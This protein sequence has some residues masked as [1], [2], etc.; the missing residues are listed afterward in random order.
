MLQKTL[1]SLL[2]FVAAI[3]LSQSAQ[4]KL[5]LTSNVTRA[6]VGQPFT[7]RCE[8]ENAKPETKDYKIEF[9]YSVNG[10][11]A[12][13]DFYS[14]QWLYKII[15]TK[16]K[17]NFFPPI[18]LDSF[19]K[20]DTAFSFQANFNDKNQRYISRL[21]PLLHKAHSGVY[22]VVVVA[23]TNFTTSFYCVKPLGII[24]HPSNYLTLAVINSHIPEP[25]T[26]AKPPQ[27]EVQ[28][29]VSTNVTE[30]YRLKEAFNLRCSIAHFE[31][32]GKRYSVQYY[33]SRDGRFAS[34]D[35]DGKETQKL[36]HI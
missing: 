9:W 24:N 26:T 3:Q 29:T 1:I 5:T 19:T 15:F 17:L 30:H 2:V 22:E 21:D 12:V 4:L 34:F 18:I 32:K 27:K 28:V 20:E 14:K 16:N 6:N 8:V 35:V 23:K 13:F 25:T 33:N 31:A 7:L 10:Q 11:L 36:T